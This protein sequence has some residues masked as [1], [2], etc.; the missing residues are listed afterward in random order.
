VRV[1]VE[2]D[3][4]VSAIVDTETAKVERVVVWCEGIEQRDGEYAIVTA[5]EEKPVRVK[6]RESAQE[7]VD[8][9]MWPAWDFG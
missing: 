6:E 8:S 1:Q 2:Y 4:P 5:E 9:V 3:V 7:I